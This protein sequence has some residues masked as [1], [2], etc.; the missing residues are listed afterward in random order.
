MYSLILSFP[1]LYLAFLFSQKLRKTDIFRLV[2]IDLQARV[3]AV[4]V[5][6]SSW[7][8]PRGAWTIQAFWETR[9]S[10][11]TKS[12]LAACPVSSK[13]GWVLL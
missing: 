8:L 13:P 12:R 7:P 2:P 4:A 3:A 6:S 11:R 9:S 5:C 10:T 1:L